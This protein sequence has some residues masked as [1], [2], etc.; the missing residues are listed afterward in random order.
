MTLDGA[1]F[2]PEFQDDSDTDVDQHREV[3]PQSSLEP[4][5]NILIAAAVPFGNATIIY[6]MW[7]VQDQV[8]QWTLMNTGG[9]AT[10]ISY[11]KFVS[12]MIIPELH[13]ID[14]PCTP[15]PIYVQ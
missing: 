8:K 6:D 4:E 2:T 3:T 1:K 5:V 11:K 7:Y 15:C 14:T 10:K 13:R 9:G 12:G